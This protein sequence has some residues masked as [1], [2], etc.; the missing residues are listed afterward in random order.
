M[1]RMTPE[2]ANLIKAIIAQ[3]GQTLRHFANECGMPYQKLAHIRCGWVKLTEQD[4]Q[5]IES[6][7]IRLYGVGIASL[8]N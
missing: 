3:H 6:T 4:M 5:T 1:S 8:N 2:T 7:L